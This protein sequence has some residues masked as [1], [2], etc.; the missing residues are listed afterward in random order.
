MGKVLKTVWV[1]YLMPVTRIFSNSFKPNQRHRHI[2]FVF[3]NSHILSIFQTV[4]DF[5]RL[6]DEAILNILEK[7]ENAVKYYVAFPLLSHLSSANVFNQV[8]GFVL[9]GGCKII[10]VISRRQ[11]TQSYLSRISLALGKGYQMSHTRHFQ[12][13]Q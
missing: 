1:T 12:W 6:S 11:L 8:D 9:Y 5:L 13:V 2:K 3:S 7:R 10:S 4:F